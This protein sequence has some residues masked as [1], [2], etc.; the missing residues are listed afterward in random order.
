MAYGAATADIRYG[1][2]RTLLHGWR[3]RYWAAGQS[4]MRLRVLLPMQSLTRRCVCVVPEV[5]SWSSTSTEAEGRKREQKK[6]R[7][8]GRRGAAL[9][10]EA[11]GA[12][13]ARSS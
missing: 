8:G 11:R 9:A 1:A 5:M 13:G 6:R 2:T 7:S 3:G 10:W 4:T 12:R